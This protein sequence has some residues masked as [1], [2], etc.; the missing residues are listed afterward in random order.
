M[1]QILSGILSILN[2]AE[3]KKLYGLILFDL[4]IGLL[5]IAFLGMLLV[6]INFYTK[7]T[8]LPKI[9]FIP[10][11][12]LNPN[13]LWL[14]GIFCVLFCLK[15]WFGFAGLK[16]QHHF[17][18]DVAS[19]LSKRN[20]AAY[21]TNDYLTFVSLDSSV[22][23]RNISQQ[24]IEFACYIL[25]NLQQV[26]SQ[27]ILVFFTICAIFFY[28]FSLSR[29]DATRFITLMLASIISFSAR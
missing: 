12:L 4:V 22:S 27:S 18:Y 16:S 9:A 26:V 14:I 3:R 15:N 17:F 8:G 20:I 13:S 5:D 24:P 6:I 28:S 25:T 7:N 29:L 19:R 10:A 23:V 1:K 21:F 2:S 11:T